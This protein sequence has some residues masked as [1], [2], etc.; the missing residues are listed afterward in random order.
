MATINSLEERS[1]LSLLVSTDLKV[2]APLKIGCEEKIRYDSK[3]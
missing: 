2:L 3:W 1:S